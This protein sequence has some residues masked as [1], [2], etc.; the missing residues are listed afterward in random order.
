MYV[1]SVPNRSGR[2]VCCHL[3]L[4]MTCVRSMTVQ[5]SRW[6]Q[7]A[8]SLLSPQQA[9]MGWVH[10]CYA[11]IIN[12]HTPSGRLL[13]S[14]GKG[15]LQ[16]PLGLAGIGKHP[17]EGFR[18]AA[19]LPPS[20]T[21]DN[22][23][24]WRSAWH[25]PPFDWSPRTHPCFPLRGVGRVGAAPNT[26]PDQGSVTSRLRVRQLPLAPVVP[27]QTDSSLPRPIVYGSH[28]L[29]PLWGPFPSGSQ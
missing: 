21:L 1:T 11:R 29:A 8:A 14:R 15:M 12:V 3:S 10:S 9:V 26:H 22:F 17:L 18:Q 16:A 6:S 13:T 25:T 23:F 19:I 4:S 7:A 20:T 24:R 27:Q 28:A 5:V 2:K